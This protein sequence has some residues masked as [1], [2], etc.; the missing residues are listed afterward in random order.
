VRIL[1]ALRT[2]PTPAVRTHD[3]KRLLDDHQHTNLAR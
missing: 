1:D 2:D 3:G